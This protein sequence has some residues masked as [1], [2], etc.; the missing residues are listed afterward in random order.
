VH[1]ISIVNE[2][3]NPRL[4]FR[5]FFFFF[6]LHRFRVM[7]R[8]LLQCL[9]ASRSVAR[10]ARLSILAPKPQYQSRIGLS[11]TQS[12]VRLLSKDSGSPYSPL[13]EGTA[14]GAPDS[15]NS[16]AIATSVFNNAWDR[17]E[18]KYGRA[19]LFVSVL[20]IHHLF[21]T[22]MIDDDLDR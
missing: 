22:I 7:S 14:K 11:S 18:K 21:M 3:L 6:F 2:N 17:I 1:N 13:S 20:F 4:P 16:I 12:T 10:T 8:V 9:Q 19:N 5:L 15:S